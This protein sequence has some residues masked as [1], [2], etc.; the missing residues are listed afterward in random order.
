MRGES[1]IICLVRNVGSLLT[2]FLVIL[3]L[4]LSPVTT[5][6]PRKAPHQTLV[7]AVT[8]QP[9]VAANCHSYASC[10]V[11]VVPSDVSRM[12]AEALQRLRFLPPEAVHLA[13]YTPLFDTPPR[14]V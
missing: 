1:Q 2:T 9:Q 14:R 6:E 3:T 12:T 7:I 5:A 8:A 13:A 4:V 11:F 10:T